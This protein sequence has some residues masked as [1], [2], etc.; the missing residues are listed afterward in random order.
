MLSLGIPKGHR[1]AADA[2]E[3]LPGLWLGGESAAAQ[4]TYGNPLHFTHVLTVND[5]PVRNLPPH[6]HTHFVC[7]YDHHS[8]DLLSIL[9]QCV[10]FIDQALYEETGNAVSGDMESKSR[11]RHQSYSADTVSTHMSTFVSD[12]DSEPETP[13]QPPSTHTHTEESPS[14]RTRHTIAGDR[15]TVSLCL[16]SPLPKRG[17][18]VLVHC[19]MGMSRSPSIIIGYLMVRKNMSLNQAID[20]VKRKRCYIFP[21]A[22]FERQLSILDDTCGDM[23]RAH[24]IYMSLV[25]GK[26]NTHTGVCVGGETCTQEGEDVGGRHHRFSTCATLRDAVSRDTETGDGEDF[27]PRTTIRTYVSNSKTAS[28]SPDTSP[29]SLPKIESRD[30]A[31]PLHSCGDGVSTRRFAETPKDFRFVNADQSPL[32]HVSYPEVCATSPPTPKRHSLHV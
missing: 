20:F 7:I 15:D 16:M 10:D 29:L 26:E 27:S 24:E 18:N 30:A 28:I 2:D 6:I 22:G 11:G 25:T 4:I 1:T 31:S 9:P 21:N 23:S 3:I 19:S 17:R 12:I 8:N 13:P 32:A 14:S 5:K